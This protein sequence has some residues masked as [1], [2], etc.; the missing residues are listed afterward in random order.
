MI[1]CC[2]SRQNERQNHAHS[3]RFYQHAAAA[4]QRP[5]N[6]DDLLL[7]EA[8]LPH[9]QIGIWCE[10]ERCKLRARLVTHPRAIDHRYAEQPPH[11]WIAQPQVLGDRQGRYEL[12]LLRNGD[13]AGGD[14]VMRA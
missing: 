10:V 9:R 5:G 13:D 12:E 8:E 6:G 7:G 1:R 11:R 2:G 3:L 14:G 4:A